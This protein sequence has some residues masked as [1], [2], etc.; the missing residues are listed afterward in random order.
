MPAPRRWPTTCGGS[1]EGRPILARRSTSAEH[2]WRWCR[3]NPWLAGANIAAAILT[4]I[5]AI[6]ST[7]AAWTFRDQLIAIRHSEAQALRARTEAR[8]Q[9]FGALQDRARAGRYSRRWASGST[10]SMPWTRRAGIGRELNLPASR[11]EPLRDE[12]IACLALPDL[13]ATGRVIRSARGDCGV[14]VRP[15]HDP[16]CPPVRRQDRGSP[17]RRR[18]GGRPLRSPGRSGHLRLRASAPTD[19]TWRPR[20][21]PGFAL[22]VWDVERRAIAVDDPG[23]VVPA[24]F[25]PDSRRIAVGHDD[26]ALLVYDLG[27]GRVIH[28]W[29][30]PAPAQDL[31]IRPD[32]TR[33]AV[34]QDEAGETRLPDR[35]CGA[36]AGWSG[37]SRCPR[38]T[39]SPGA[40]TA[41]RWRR[42]VSDLEDLPLG[43]RHRRPEG[44]PRGLDQRRPARGLPPRRHAPGQQRLGGPAAALGC[45]P[46]SPRPEPDRLGP[47]PNSAGTDGSSSASRTG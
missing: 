34:V 24:G 45:G 29:R 4:T 39:R 43:C 23:P 8:E 22:T 2:F 47:A 37:R 40:P 28:R 26:G 1:C 20:I 30:G 35:G 44:D 41:R 9:L 10:A 25:F 16:L 3:R 46:G 15:G 19:A 13:K 31:A 12:A 38:R 11:L 17:R 27:T 6:G 42:R 14:R 36:R 33:I 32:G 21:I 5:I 18:R 7:V